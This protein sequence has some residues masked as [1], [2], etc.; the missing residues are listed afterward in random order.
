MI[1]SIIK[2]IPLLSKLPFD[3]LE[4]QKLSGLSNRNYLIFTQEQRYI[5]RIPRQSTNRFINRDSESYN[6]EIAQQLGIA[7]KC[8]W[9]G[10]GE[11]EGISLTEF[12]NNTNHFESD[13][14]KPINTFAKTLATL[15]R[16][17][18]PFKST[19]DNKSIAIKLNQYFKLCSCSQQ[20][21]LKADYQKT[22]SLLETPLCKRPSVPSHIDLITENILQQDNKIW[23]IDWEY[24]AMASPFWDIAI[25][26]NSAGLD[27]NRSKKLLK[28]VLDNN[29]NNDIQCLEDYR[30]I[31]QVV[32][33]CWQMAFHNHPNSTNAKA[34]AAGNA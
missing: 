1:E 29:Q 14:K 24:S 11:Q 12:I 28:Q 2:S 4:I 7:P 17:K 20:K 9:R 23:L 15:H 8:L 5:L 34:I 10:E 25:F 13:N 26:C 3:T 33:D 19:L 18:K 22:L 32:S 21:L 27:S 6:A 31:T 30:L 16:S